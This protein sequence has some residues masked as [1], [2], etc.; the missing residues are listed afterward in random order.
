MPAS[1]PH[2]A[3]RPHCRSARRTARTW[4]AADGRSSAREDRR[5]RSGAASMHPRDRRVR[6]RY[7]RC[8]FAPVPAAFRPQVPVAGLPWDS[9]GCT[10]HTTYS[11]SG[12]RSPAATG[13]SAKPARPAA[14]RGLPGS[15]RQRRDA[16]PGPC[17]Q[18]RARPRPRKPVWKAARRLPERRPHQTVL[19]NHPAPAHPASPRPPRSPAAVRRAADAGIRDR[20]GPQRQ[21]PRPRRPRAGGRPRQAECRGVASALRLR[22]RQRAHRSQT[23]PSVSDGR[24]P[25]SGSA[26]AGPPQW[27][28]GSTARCRAG[29]NAPAPP[30]DT[31]PYTPR[32]AGKHRDRCAAPPGR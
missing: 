13:P 22:R 24:R 25:G 17:G 15:Q 29:R 2:G 21:Q 11:A 5:A 31:R 19:A 3:R 28:P 26:A 9:P 18:P 7:S 23:A 6:T 30:S 4:P 27:P 20:A 16:R 14:A 8:S 1:S 12:Q 32:T 10:N